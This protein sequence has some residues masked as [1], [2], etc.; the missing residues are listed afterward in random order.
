VSEQ[1]YTIQKN[2]SETAKVDELSTQPFPGSKKLYIKAFNESNQ[3]DIHVALREIHL[4]P[5]Q[6]ANDKTEYNPPVRIYDTSGSYSDPDKIIDVRKGLDSLRKNWIEGRNDT[7]ILSGNSS[8]YAKIR[9][10][11]IA[12]ESLRFDLQRSPIR[13]KSG[14]NVTQLHYA[15]QGIITPE[16]QYIAIRENLA[17][18]EDEMDEHNK[19]QHPGENF[20]AATPSYITAEFV[21]SEVARG[22][23]VIPANINHPESEPMIIGR[24]FLTKVNANIGNSALTSSI[25]EEVEKLVWSTRWGADTVMDLSTGKNIH[26]TREWIA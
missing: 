10:M 16:M 14:K 5:T 1:T 9:E 4:S 15:R 25:E 18:A 2:L 8:D 3:S 26:E 6:L 22:R 21:R 23:A 13:A 20:G 11:N 24:N 17:M 12:L 19:H 7:E